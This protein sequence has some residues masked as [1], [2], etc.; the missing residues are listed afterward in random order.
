MDKQNQDNFYREFLYEE[1]KHMTT[2]G[3][4]RIDKLISDLKR[5]RKNRQRAE[6]QLQN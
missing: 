5:T 1:S 3:E 4:T 2:P 6:L